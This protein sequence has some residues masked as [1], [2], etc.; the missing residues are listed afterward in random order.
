MYNVTFKHFPMPSNIPEC[1]WSDVFFSA[2]AEWLLNPLSYKK[3]ARQK[4]LDVAEDKNSS[5]LF[6][7]TGIEASYLLSFHYFRPSFREIA[8]LAS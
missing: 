2:R 5:D 8:T 6:L 1:P 7:Y 4:Q 3:A